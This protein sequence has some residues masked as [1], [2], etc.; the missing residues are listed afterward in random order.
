M[1]ETILTLAQTISGSTDTEK[2][3]LDLLCTAAE[4][5]W[6]GRLR[7]GV[8]AEDCKEPFTCAAAFTAVARLLGSRSGR[9]SVSSF[10]A[11]SVSV[12]SLSMAEASAASAA[13]Q[14]QAE[15]MM[16]PYV[17]EEGFS[18]HGVRA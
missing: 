11:G 5:E 16:V 1:H 17:E 4:R 6:N 18:F 8:S 7:E 12:S 13:L 3:L 14:S 15:Q 9:N 10:T 2:A